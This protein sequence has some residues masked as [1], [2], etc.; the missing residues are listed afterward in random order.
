MYFRQAADE[1]PSGS[2]LSWVNI[3]GDLDPLK[4]LSRASSFVC[5]VGP[6]KSAALGKL[7]QLLIS[8]CFVR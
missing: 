1:R 6:G 8:V 5:D 4:T 7:V 3:R 2:G